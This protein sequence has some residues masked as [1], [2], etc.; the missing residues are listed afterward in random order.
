MSP[1]P[2]RLYTVRTNA[3][4]EHPAAAFLLM[5]IYLGFCIPS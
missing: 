3:T 1:E 5:S 4:N 2:R